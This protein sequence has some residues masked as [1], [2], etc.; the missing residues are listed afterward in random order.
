MVCVCDDE[1]RAAAAQNR[2]RALKILNDE[3]SDTEV[4]MQTTSENLITAVVSSLE[5]NYRAG[6]V[7]I[8]CDQWF[9][10]YATTGDKS[11][12]AAIECDRVEDGFVGLF[13]AFYDRFGDARREA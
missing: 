3:D 6:P 10:V 7:T 8:A 12:T 9:G 5:W 1:G 13:L 4:W 11:F 2:E